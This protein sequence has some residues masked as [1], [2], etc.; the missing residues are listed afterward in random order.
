MFELENVSVSTILSIRHLMIKEGDVTCFVGESGGGK[1]T[2]LKLLNK[3]LSPDGGKVFFRG[4]ALEDINSVMHR[5][6]VLYLNQ[7]P[8]IFSGTIRDNLIK[9]F[10]LQNRA[11]P[12]HETLIAV[13]KRVSLKK[14]LDD[15]AAVL[16]GGE[17]QRLALARLMLLDGEVYLM[18]EPS[19]ALDDAMELKI[20]DMIVRFVKEEG[21]TL[22][23]VTHSKAIASKFSDKIY[24]VKSGKIEE[25]SSNES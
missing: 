13:L 17:K 21:K 19:S 2:I 18:D 8:H 25:V 5:R 4:E 23:M 24:Q 20:I 1:T 3:A 7:T 16:S 12:N 14:N 15:E 11:Y 6:K 9:G 22:V 10:E